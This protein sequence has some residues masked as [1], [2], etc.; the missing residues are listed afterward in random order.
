TGYN[1]TCHKNVLGGHSC[2]TFLN[3]FDWTYRTG[4]IKYNRPFQWNKAR[5]PWNNLLPKS[6]LVPNTDVPGTEAFM[7]G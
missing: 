1:S 4:T 6:A 2:I 3:C 7:S 5:I